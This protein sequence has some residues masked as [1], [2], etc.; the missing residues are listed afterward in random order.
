MRKPEAQASILSLLAQA[1]LFSGKPGQAAPMFQLHNDI[2]GKVKSLRSQRNL[3][4]GLR[5]L[6]YAVSLAGGLRGLKPPRFVACSLRMRYQIA[7]GKQS[8]YVGWGWGWRQEAQRG[9]LSLFY[10]GRCGSWSGRTHKGKVRSVLFSR[11]CAPC[12]SAI[13][14]LCRWQTERGKS[15]GS[16]RQKHTATSSTGADTGRGDVRIG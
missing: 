11:R 3:N 7:L 15:R 8:A 10:S 6:S 14:P 4:I 2:Q 1:Y 9:C 12:G 5:N 16:Q 13:P